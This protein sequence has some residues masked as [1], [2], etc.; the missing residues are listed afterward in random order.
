M[1]QPET[2]E[3]YFQIIVNTDTHGLLFREILGEPTF[4]RCIGCLPIQIPF[5]GLRSALVLMAKQQQPIPVA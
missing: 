4:I 5:Y 2:F 3:P 1:Q